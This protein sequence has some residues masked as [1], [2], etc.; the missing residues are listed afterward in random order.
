MATT[1]LV[2]EEG[3]A[4]LAHLKVLVELD[5]MVPQVS[6][7]LVGLEVEMVEGAVTTR[8]TLGS[9][10]AFNPEVVEEEKHSRGPHLA[11][12]LKAEL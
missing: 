9:Q 8:K 6:A 12:A 3:E 10:M 1:V 7:E 5:R 11:M 4:V 2:Q